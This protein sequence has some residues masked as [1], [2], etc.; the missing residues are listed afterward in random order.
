MHLLLD[1]IVFYSF[2]IASDNLHIIEMFGQNFHLEFTK[3]LTPSKQT[4][5]KMHQRK[6]KNNISKIL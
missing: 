1:F 4:R 2:N 3:A 6:V 5:R